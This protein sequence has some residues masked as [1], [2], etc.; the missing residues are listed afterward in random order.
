MTIYVE[1]YAGMACGA[2]PQ[3]FQGVPQ[4]STAGPVTQVLAGGTVSTIA[5]AANTNFVVFYNT[6][7]NGFYIWGGSST[8]S[9]AG[10]STYYIPGP[11]TLGGG[12]PVPIMRG[13]KP[14]AK[15]FVWS[16]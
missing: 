11:S 6:L 16:T 3:R 5:L 4:L 8:G 12:T 10:G 13:V 1:E 2:S 15:L 7:P 14:N 9:T